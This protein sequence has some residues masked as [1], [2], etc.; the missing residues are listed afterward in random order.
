[1]DRLIQSV[2]LRRS[3]GVAQQN[4]GVG[5]ID[6]R[7]QYV[8]DQLQ[9][10]ALTSN[11]ASDLRVGQLFLELGVDETLVGYPWELMYDGDNY[12][13]LKHWMGRFVNSAA[14]TAALPREASSPLGKEIQKLS[15]LLISVPQPCERDGGGVYEELPGARAEAEALTNLLTG[16]PDVEL[17]VLAKDEAT[18]E[19]VFQ[20]LRHNR[21]DIIHFTGH[22]S[23]DDGDPLQSSLVLFD[24][25][26]A[27]IQIR[28]LI[29]RTPPVLCFI[30]ACDSAAT[31]EWSKSYNIYGLAQS[32]L[33]TGT[34]LLGSRWK[35]SDRGAPIFAEAFYRCLLDE[36]K[37][38]GRAVTEGRQAS[39]DKAPDDLAWA[40]YVLY[41]DPRL[42]F[43]RSAY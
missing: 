30:N 34:Y 40:S 35:L 19:A 36:S 5:S 12:L 4:P 9:M 20:R 16:L 1:L 37:A 21:Y 39:K 27:A 29:T 15:V 13:C 26:L 41:G 3:P 17:E 8:G 31:T 25:D 11:V 33:Q 6:E 7:V 18:Y 2:R 43:R 10:Y 24:Q 38:L 23:L 22:A 32:F 28:A 42:Q 14:G